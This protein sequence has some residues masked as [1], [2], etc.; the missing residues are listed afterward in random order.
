MMLAALLVSINMT[1]AEVTEVTFLKP[2]EPKINL[3][4]GKKIAMS[5]NQAVVGADNAES[6]RGRAYVLEVNPED[7]EWRH[8]LTLTADPRNDGG[9]TD[10]D[11]FGTSV[12]ISGNTI[13]V[14]CPGDDSN[15]DPADTSLSGSGAVYIF[16]HEGGSWQQQAYLKAA[17][18]VFNSGFGS[19]VAMD[20]DTL[21][22]AT[23]EFYETNEKSGSGRVHIFQRTDSNWTQI[24]VLDSPYPDSETRFAGALALEGNL[25]AVGVP[26]DGSSASGIGGDSTSKNAVRSGAAWIYEN[27]DGTWTQDAYVKAS[28]THARAEFGA[29]I[30][31]SSGRILVG[32]P[33]EKSRGVGVN[34]DQSP[35]LIQSPDFGAAYVFAKSD[36]VD[37]QQQVYLKAPDRNHQANTFINDRFG[38]S[39]AISGNVILIGAEGDDNPTRGINGDL[40]GVGASASGAAHLFRFADDTGWRYT[41]FIKASNAD[42]SDAFGR[43]VA[44]SGAYA[45]VGAPGE[46]SRSHLTPED[47]SIRSTGAI[48]AYLISPSDGETPDGPFLFESITFIS[49]PIAGRIAVSASISGPPNSSAIIERAGEI[50]GEDNWTGISA[51][52]LDPS[53]S[54]SFEGFIESTSGQFFLRLRGN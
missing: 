54:G 6:F 3:G 20:G 9:N 18:P 49:T 14:G 30:A 41:D 8:I 24:Q 23:G 19:Q 48:Y 21:A 29:A 1:N 22:V 50:V 25:L 12:A 26:M 2:G 28:N 27:V 17:Q 34:G 4:F 13:A 53:G 10:F 40:A 43:T 36:S 42:S 52:T 31:I 35:D 45:L 7:G 38:G 11:A 37:W 46:S 47:N 16:V 51:T 44:M 32:S 5:G 39:L 15:G 33:G